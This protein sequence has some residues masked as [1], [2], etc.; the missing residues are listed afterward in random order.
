MNCFLICCTKTNR[1]Q[2]GIFYGRGGG[3]ECKGRAGK[4]LRVLRVLPNGTQVGIFN[5]LDIDISIYGKTL[6]KVDKS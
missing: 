5:E 2:N 3:G 4:V 1:P 6:I